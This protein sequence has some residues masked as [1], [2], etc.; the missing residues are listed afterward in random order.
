MGVPWNP[1]PKITD[2]GIPEMLP[3][4]Q[5]INR[6]NNKTEHHNYLRTNGQDLLPQSVQKP[7]FGAALHQECNK[8]D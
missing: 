7:V 1:E 3:D 8:L 4:C 5:R 6:K 2:H